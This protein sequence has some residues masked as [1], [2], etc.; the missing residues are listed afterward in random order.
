M[1]FSNQ[2]CQNEKI[3]INKFPLPMPPLDDDPFATLSTIDI[4][5]M[6]AAP[7]VEEDG[8]GSEYE[9]EKEGEEDDEDYDE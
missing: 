5:A 9:D 4:T 2:R 6:E 7:N 1:L 8:S 3:G